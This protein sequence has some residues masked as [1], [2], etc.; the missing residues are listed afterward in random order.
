MFWVVFEVKTEIKFQ[1]G[2][3]ANNSIIIQAHELT[4]VVY[5]R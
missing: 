1:N 5:V 4:D 2:K 3:S